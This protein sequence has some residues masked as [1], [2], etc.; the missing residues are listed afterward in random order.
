[1]SLENNKNSAVKSPQHIL[2]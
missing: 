1:M 2:R